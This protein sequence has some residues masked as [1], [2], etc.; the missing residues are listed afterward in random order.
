[1]NIEYC[2]M[3]ENLQN[4]CISITIAFLRIHE[5][6][7]DILLNSGLEILSLDFIKAFDRVNHLFL[8]INF[9]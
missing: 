2:I 7:T 1:M 5:T 6:V 9:L 8:S 4:Y 3:I